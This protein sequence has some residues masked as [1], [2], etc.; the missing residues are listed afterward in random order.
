MYHEVLNKTH[1]HSF[2]AIRSAIRS[3]QLDASRGVAASGRVTRRRGTVARH[4]RVAQ[5]AR[6]CLAIDAGRRDRQECKGQRAD[7]SKWCHSLTCNETTLSIT[8]Q[9][10]IRHS[11]L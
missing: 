3:V 4:D 10:S 9:N 11:I 7:D 2:T 1:S 8:S 5:K 6:E